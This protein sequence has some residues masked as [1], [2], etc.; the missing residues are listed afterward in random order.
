MIRGSYLQAYVFSDGA[1]LP[2]RQLGVGV[3]NDWDAAVGVYAGELGLFDLVPRNIL[4]SVGQA[5]L[6]E[7]HDHL[8]RA[9][10]GLGRPTALVFLLL[11]TFHGLK[12]SPMKL[13]ASSLL[14]SEMWQGVALTRNIDCNRLHLV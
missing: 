9:S 7:N 13:S 4:H 5:E 6:L 8:V 14:W 3:D 2:Q 12:A 10:A 1:R 11:H